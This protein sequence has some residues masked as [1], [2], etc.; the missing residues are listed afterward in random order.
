MLRPLEAAFEASRRWRSRREG[1]LS[2][3]GGYGGSGSRSWPS[4][5]VAAVVEEDAV[6]F[7]FPPRHIRA[8]QTRVEGFQVY[9]SE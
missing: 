3:V 6:P 4:T 8:R 7:A 2:P 1:V 9:D 5:V